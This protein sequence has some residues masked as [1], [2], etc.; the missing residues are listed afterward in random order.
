MVAIPSGPKYRIPNRYTENV[1]RPGSYGEYVN[2]KF[3]ERLR[4]DPA[5]PH[6]MKGPNYSHYH[7]DGKP[8]HYSPHPQATDPG[9]GP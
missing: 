5:T 8:T 7:R 9:F 1:Y 6:G 3:V 2:G 4:T